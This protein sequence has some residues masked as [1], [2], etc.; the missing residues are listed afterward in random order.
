MFTAS[1]ASSWPRPRQRRSSSLS[2]DEEDI[3]NL[4]A[5]HTFC[6]R[7]ASKQKTETTESE[8]GGKSGKED[9]DT[10]CLKFVCLSRQIAE[11]GSVESFRFL[12]H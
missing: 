10:E 6:G 1:H 9:G 12:T 11:H 4:V 3:E 7:E 8:S 2:I 5:R